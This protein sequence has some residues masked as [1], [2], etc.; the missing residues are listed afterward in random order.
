[1]GR[2]TIDFDPRQAQPTGSIVAGSG[3]PVAFAGWLELI[4]RLEE[5]TSAGVAEGAVQGDPVRKEPR[6]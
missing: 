5:L 2:V 6:C 1:M 4:S 3:P